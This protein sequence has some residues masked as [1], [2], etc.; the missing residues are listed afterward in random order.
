MIIL[1]FLILNDD[2]MKSIY[3]N[4]INLKIYVGLIILYVG[5]CFVML[6]ISDFIIFEL[7]FEYIII[8]I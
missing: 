6:I 4:E 8:Y 3:Y 2:V 5:F 1:I 7:I